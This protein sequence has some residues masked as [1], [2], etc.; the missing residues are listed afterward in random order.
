MSPLMVLPKAAYRVCTNRAGD[1]AARILGCRVSVR[2][3][4]APPDARRCSFEYALSEPIAAWRSQDVASASLQDMN[5]RARSANEGA[6]ASGTAD[7]L[8]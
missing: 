1:R 4:L 7:A 6:E 5:F 2:H 8:Q 3:A